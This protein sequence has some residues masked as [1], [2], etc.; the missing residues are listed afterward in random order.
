MLMRGGSFDFA[1]RW[2]CLGAKANVP[3]VGRFRIFLSEGFCLFFL[4]LD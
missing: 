3:F 1:L 2:H 4:G